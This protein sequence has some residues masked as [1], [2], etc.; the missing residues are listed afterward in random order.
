[1]VNYQEWGLTV[2]NIMANDLLLQQ[3]IPL[4]EYTNVTMGLQF[5][6]AR[7]KIKASD[8]AAYEK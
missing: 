1:M 2:Q 7:D 4:K 3:R 8:K 6:K 5:S